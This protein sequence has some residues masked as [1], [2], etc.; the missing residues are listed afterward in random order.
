MRLHKEHSY[1]CIDMEK[2][3]NMTA[4]IILVIPLISF[5]YGSLQLMFLA[6]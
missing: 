4:V 6:N 1:N 5:E 2:W 3:F